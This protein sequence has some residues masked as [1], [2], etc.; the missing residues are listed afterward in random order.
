[1]S[2][3]GTVGVTALGMA[4][5]GGGWGLA[6]A[7]QSLLLVVGG[8][9][10]K[11]AVTGERIEPRDILSLTVAFD[12]DVVDGA[13]A[14]RFVHRLTDLIESGHERQTGSTLLQRLALVDVAT[15]REVWMLYSSF[16]R[17]LGPGL[18]WA[19]GP[20]AQAIAVGTT[21]G[22]PNIP[23]S[24]QMP[25]LNWE[26][27][28]GDLRL[29]PALLR[30]DPDPQP[31]RVRLAGL[32][33][34]ATVVR[35]GRRARA[36]GWRTGRRGPAHEPARN[37]VGQRASLAGA[38]HHRGRRLA[39]LVLAPRVRFCTKRQNVALLAGH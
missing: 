30:P 7:G 21:G 9:T 24:P 25:T 8:I 31:G 35:V 10:R 5:R 28:A 38:G 15:D 33:A 39:R 16:L 17:A 22:G 13:P 26:Q 12:H 29:A 4:G 1:V 2:A 37:L 32:A 34:P 27:L 6:P 11:P 14:A 36:T 20:E 19:Y 18:I 3:A 23:G